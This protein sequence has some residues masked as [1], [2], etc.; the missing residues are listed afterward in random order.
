MNTE[1]KKIIKR[2]YSVEE[3]AVYLG[4]SEWSVR[5]LLWNGLLPEVRIG[6]RVQVDIRDLDVFIEHNKAQLAA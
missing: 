1:P 3:A 5:R 4:R 2:L 6:R